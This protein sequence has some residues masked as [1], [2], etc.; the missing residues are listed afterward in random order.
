MT[1]SGGGTGGLVGNASSAIITQSYATGTVNGASTAGG[2]VGA[3]SGSLSISKSYAA[4]AVSGTSS[5]GGLIGSLTGSTARI[6]ESYATGSVSGTTNVGG[7]VG[8]LTSTAGISE[9]YAT[10]AVSGTT[11][12]GGLIGSMS[13]TASLSSSFFDATTT[14]RTDGVGSNSTASGVTALTTAEFQDT[15]GFMTAAAT[16]NYTGS[17]APPSAGYYPQLYAVNPVSTV[18]GGISSSVYGSS[19]GTLS[20]FTGSSGGPSAYGFGPSGD[21]ITLAGIS[22][23]ANA[24]ANAGT[25]ATD[26]SLN[27]SLTSTGG[28]TYRVFVYGSGTTTVTA[29]PISVTA[30]AKPMTYGDA[31]PSLTYAITSG[32]LLNGD[33]LTGSLATLASSTANVGTYAITLGTLGNPN[34][35]ITYTGADVTVSA[36]AITVTADGQSMAYG[37][38][39]PTLT[40]TVGG[41]GLVNG[42]T[43]SGALATAATSTSNVGSYAI[44]QGTL[45]N[46]NYAVTYTGANLAVTPAT[47]TVTAADGSM[48]FGGSVPV[49]G[50]SVSGWKNQQT[51]SLLT[52]VSV[53]ANATSASAVGSGYITVASG[54]TLSGAAAGNYTLTYQQGQFTVVAG[55]GGSTPAPLPPAAVDPSLPPPP[56]VIITQPV[57]N[58]VFLVVASFGPGPQQGAGVSM[59]QPQA[60][61]SAAASGTGPSGDAGSS[62]SMTDLDLQLTSGMCPLGPDFTI[63]CSSN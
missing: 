60:I 34:Y 4:T 41:S 56:A 62:G 20:G 54:G 37:D 1:G 63:S 40:Y 13:G 52:G 7:L 16:W 45:G 23:A 31:L 6:T 5:V 53:T 24:A 33:T 21:S 25:T 39:V 38:A 48:V 43:L 2:L 49:L 11:N 9:S 29:R 55:S 42:D 15:A 12:V 22:L 51:D 58:P 27:T 50:Y 3:G 14:G 61:V 46:S 17:W 35:A 10:G 19:T 59:A 32:S 47:L 44:T 28:L 18:T 57:F 8:S 36:R 26:F 30:D